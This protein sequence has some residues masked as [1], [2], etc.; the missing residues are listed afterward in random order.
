[1]IV[2]IIGPILWTTGFLIRE[3]N[4]GN[5]YYAS[6]TVCSLK[7]MTENY[8]RYTEPQQIACSSHSPVLPSFPFNRN[9]IVYDIMHKNFIASLWDQFKMYS[10]NEL[11]KDLH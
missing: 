8:K 4:K 5:D 9:V 10:K 6:C 11:C 2:C 3:V 1:M 7:V